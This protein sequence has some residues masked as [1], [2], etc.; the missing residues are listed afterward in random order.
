MNLQE[1]SQRYKSVPLYKPSEDMVKLYNR[2]GEKSTKI[3]KL[4][5][6]EN[7]FVSKSFVIDLVKQAASELDPRLYPQKEGDQLKEKI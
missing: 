6:N 3:L 1:L 4:N 7:H 2:F 5:A